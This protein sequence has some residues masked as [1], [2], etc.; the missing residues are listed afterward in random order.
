VDEGGEAD[1][2]TSKLA[3]FPSSRDAEFER[4]HTYTCS[5][6][7]TKTF[8]SDGSSSLPCVNQACRGRMVR[9]SVPTGLLAD[10]HEVLESPETCWDG[11]TGFLKEMA[12]RGWEFR[13][14]WPPGSEVPRS[15]VDR[16]LVEISAWLLETK[17]G[18]IG[19]ASVPD[20]GSLTREEQK[21]LGWTL[22]SLSD[23]LIGSDR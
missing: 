15:H 4:Q 19:D 2:P 14:T 21:T 22:R 3:E 16:K 1:R 8:C 12:R 20:L 5:D 17:E 10:T 11:P 7:R 9:A 6:C 18:T 13:R 23:D